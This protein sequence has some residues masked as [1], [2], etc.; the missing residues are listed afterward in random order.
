MITF[1]PQAPVTSDVQYIFNVAM[2]DP[3]NITFAYKA[4]NMSFFLTTYQQCV[5]DPECQ[6]QLHDDTTIITVCVFVLVILV[7]LLGSTKALRSSIQH[8]MEMATLTTARPSKF[9]ARNFLSP[10]RQPSA[11]K[12][13]DKYKARS[14]KT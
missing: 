11:K 13:D 2:R 6:S 5:S 8:T 10:S 12:A 9:G 3:N 7:M 14:P 1:L 4:S